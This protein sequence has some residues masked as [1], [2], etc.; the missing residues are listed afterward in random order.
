MIS[1]SQ[2]LQEQA[3]ERKRRSRRPVHANPAKTNRHPR[4]NGSRVGFAT[5]LPIA[6]AVRALVDHDVERTFELADQVLSQ[7][8]SRL[9]VIG[10][11]LYPAQLE[12]SDL[13]YSGAVTAWQEVEAARVVRQVIDK[14]PSTPSRNPVARGL[15]CVLATLPTDSDD[16]DMRM[17]ALGLEDDGW[18]VELHSPTQPL[19]EWV[20][21]ASRRPTR[22]L[23]LSVALPP[24]STR[25]L[26]QI[27]DTAHRERT[28]VLVGG[29]AF[30][31]L[32]SLRDRIGA[33][34]YG[35]DVRTGCV[36]A[37]RLV[38]R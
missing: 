16:L 11:L 30:A 8:G 38:R 6:E 33:E 22:L 17:L 9:A 34:A 28:P 31:R 24:P 3:P 32:A 1:D 14:L 20:R 2:A 19:G 5:R 18:E 13:W 37:R 10:D 15:R 25:L 23:A 12:L 21:S 35:P 29:V 26:T 7:T 27:V 36:L 4:A